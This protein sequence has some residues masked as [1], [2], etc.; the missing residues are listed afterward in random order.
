MTDNFDI[1]VKI[2]ERAETYAKRH[3]IQMDTRLTSIMDIDNAHQQHPLDLEG[4]LAADDANFVHDFFGI[5]QH[6]NRK[7]GLLEDCFL[8]RFTIVA[9][10]L[11]KHA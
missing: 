5:R 11:E 1:I 8:P 2:I 3:A 9:S 10:N 7:T 4:W 6:I